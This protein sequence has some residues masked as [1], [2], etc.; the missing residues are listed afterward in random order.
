[1][2]SFDLSDDNV[3]R[4][5]R[6]LAIAAYANEPCRICGRMLTVDDIQQN[7]VFA[8]YAKDAPSRSA[9]K[10]CWDAQP[11]KHLWVYPEDATS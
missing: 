4:A 7:A 5:A 9:H 2:I 1:M 8:G 11:P 3:Q 6:D 10:T